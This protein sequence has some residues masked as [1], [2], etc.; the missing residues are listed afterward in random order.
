MLLVQI[1][2][3]WNVQGRITPM[4]DHRSQLAIQLAILDLISC[5]LLARILMA[6]QA[7]LNLAFSVKKKSTGRVMKHLGCRVNTGKAAFRGLV[8]KYTHHAGDPDPALNPCS[9]KP[10][11]WS[12]LPSLHKRWW[13]NA[14]VRDS[15]I[16]YGRKSLKDGEPNF[17]L[18]PHTRQHV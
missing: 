7:I 10:L 14:P 4:R 16:S 11:P 5:L 18:P 1:S 8:V 12:L 17:Y 6:L 9:T 2:P 3:R 15:I 13:T